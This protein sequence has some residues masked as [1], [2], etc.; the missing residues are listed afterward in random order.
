MKNSAPDMQ[1]GRHFSTGN[2]EPMGAGRASVGPS[3]IPSSISTGASKGSIRQKKQNGFRATLRRMFGSKKGHPPPLDDPRK[4]YHRSDPG[5]LTAITERSTDINIARAPSQAGGTVTR[6]S[7]L[8]SHG[9]N[10]DFTLESDNADHTNLPSPGHR[11]RNTLPSLV[12]SDSMAQIL[13]GPDDQDLT[14]RTR[15]P[16]TLPEPMLKRRSRSADALNRMISDI[17]LRNAVNR[18]RQSDIAYW[19]K[20]IVENP[21]P[22]WPP[23]QQPTDRVAPSTRAEEVSQESVPLHNFDFGLD[24]EQGREAT[25]E[26]RVNT[27]EVKLFDFEFAIANLQGHDIPKPAL[28][29]KLPKRRSIHGLFPPEM[30]SGAESSSSTPEPTSFLTSPDNSPLPLEEPFRPDRSSKATIRPLNTQRTSD[31]QSP[32]PVRIT[33]D[34]FDRIMDII[35]REQNSRRQLEAQVNELQS[36]LDALRSPVYAEIRERTDYP[37]P[38]S[39]QGTPALN[40]TLKRSPPFSTGKKAAE[41]SRFSMSEVDSDTD[42]GFDEA[43]E[44]PQDNTFMFEHPRSSPMIGV[45]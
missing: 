44:T 28:P 13:A 35:R 25:L 11:R 5:N 7:A 9:L 24:R 2:L 10:L 45:S 32:S 30:D 12:I 16:D 26:D 8:A 36:Q 4:D 6:A 15:G 34:Q 39:K 27:L 22:A 20:S 38:N 33:V 31:A 3:L 1:R 41:Q 42:G 21:P 14:S 19:R 43:F 37:T 29:Q 17:T 40:K 18:D 23:W